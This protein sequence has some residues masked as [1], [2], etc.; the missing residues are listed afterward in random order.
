MTLV[1]LSPVDTLTPAMR[2]DALSTYLESAKQWLASAV[3]MTG[4]EQIAAA[5]AELKSVEDIAHNLNLSKDCKLDATEMVRRC[6]FELGR[7]IRKGQAEGN[8]RTKG[9]RGPQPDYIR[10]R[11]GQEQ[12]IAVGA[13]SG[14]C[15][16]PGV[17][18][19]APEFYDNGAQIAKLS[20]GVE[21][22]RFETAL[23]EAKSEGNL[24]R[25]N[26]VRKI[27][28]QAGPTSRDSRADLIVELAAQGY[29]SRQM[30]NK[31]GV[32]EETVRQIARD[33]GIEIPADKI[34]GRTRR[35]DSNRIASET[36]AALEGL[37]MGVDLINYADLNDAEKAHWADSLTHSLRA[38]NRF[39]K[40]IK[41]TTQ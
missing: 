18:D 30:P 26:V 22:E 5:K 11:A 3:E 35:H 7:A 13:D 39:A 15:Y 21:P 4:P 41:E 8:I 40:Q 20:D 31:I 14:N 9:E 2:E 6:E 33:F 38:L 32:S 17:K 36:V 1:P 16:K 28:Q 24:S 34:V 23:T 12:H 10:M 27:R 29:S 37:A 19:I 25:A